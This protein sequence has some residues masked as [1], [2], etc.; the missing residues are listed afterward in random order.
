MINKAAAIVPM[1]NK[2]SS[3]VN[4]DSCIDFPN[5]EKCSIE[6]N[7]ACQKPECDHHHQ[8]IG[9]IKKCRHKLINVQLCIKVEDGVHQ[10]VDGRPTGN[11]KTSPPPMIIF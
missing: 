6:A 3:S 4:F 11:E 2:W 8:G 9:E 10:Y 1:I 7:C 5:E